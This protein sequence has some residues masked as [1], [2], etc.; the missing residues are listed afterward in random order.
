MRCVPLSGQGTTSHET[1]GTLNSLPRISR[2]NVGRLDPFWGPQVP[3]LWTGVSNRLG[4]A[5][6]RGPTRGVLLALSRAPHLLSR[7]S[8]TS[9]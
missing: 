3:S 8:S 7:G 9:L 4:L 2:V 1:A 6:G 5:R